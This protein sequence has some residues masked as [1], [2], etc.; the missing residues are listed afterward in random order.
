[1]LA[2]GCRDRK[3]FL[4]EVQLFVS[5]FAYPTL[6]DVENVLVDALAHILPFGRLSLVTKHRLEQ[7][8]IQWLAANGF[9]N[10]GV[11]TYP[12]AGNRVELHVH[13]VYERFWGNVLVSLAFGAY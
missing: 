5:G 11:K 6:G 10:T 12:G 1:M 4:R 7:D 9:Q 8:D 3:L 2:A 13:A